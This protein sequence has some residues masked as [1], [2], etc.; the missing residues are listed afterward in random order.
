MFYNFYIPKF[1][2]EEEAFEFFNH[3]AYASEEHADK[4]FFHLAWIVLTFNFAFMGGGILVGLENISYFVWSFNLIFTGYVLM[5]I[6]AFFKFVRIWNT[7]PIEDDPFYWT[8]A[9][10]VWA[11]IGKRICD[12]TSLSCIV[13]GMGVFLYSIWGLA[14]EDI[15]IFSE[16][17]ILGI[18]EVDF[19]C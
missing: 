9:K 3:H 4:L 6:S 1:K 8:S 12:W 15:P 16:C 14:N 2:S 7:I 5:P 11:N 10:G 19:G 17:E 18:P 13:V